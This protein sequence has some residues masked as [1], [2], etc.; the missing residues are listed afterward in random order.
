MVRDMLMTIEAT[1]MI[2][3]TMN[4]S[5]CGLEAQCRFARKIGLRWEKGDNAGV[6]IPSD[7]KRRLFIVELRRICSSHILS[8][9][10]L[11]TPDIIQFRNIEISIIIVGLTTTY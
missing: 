9:Q 1:A 3:M 6:F 4:I 2:A 7:L 11:P 8:K 5:Y 10:Q